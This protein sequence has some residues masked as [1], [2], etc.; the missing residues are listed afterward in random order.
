MQSTSEN[1]NGSGASYNSSL[2]LSSGI[3]NTV[4]M[5]SLGVGALAAKYSF[6]VAIALLASI[7]VLGRILG[8]S[9]LPNRGRVA[10]RSGTIPKV[11]RNY[12][13]I[14]SLAYA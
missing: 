10:R 12:L 14:S 6:N 5:M 8:Y 2:P 11:C 13:V 9:S 4:A 1:D 7:Y 3:K